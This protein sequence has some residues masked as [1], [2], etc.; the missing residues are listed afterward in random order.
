MIKRSEVVGFIKNLLLLSLGIGT[1]RFR[2]GVQI[3]ASSP[4][5]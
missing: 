4:C 2:I 3:P 5:L 1:E